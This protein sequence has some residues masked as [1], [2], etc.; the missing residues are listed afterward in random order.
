MRLQGL[1]G[2]VRLQPRPLAPSHLLRE[3]GPLADVL[4]HVLHDLP[5]RF[6]YVGPVFR[7]GRQ[8]RRQGF[9]ER[10]VD[11]VGFEPFLYGSSA[12][13]LPRAN[14]AFGVV[15]T[16]DDQQTQFPLLGV[17]T[18]AQGFEPT[19][20]HVASFVGHALEADVQLP[21]LA[22]TRHGD[23]LRA[24]LRESQHVRVRGR[25]WG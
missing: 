12:G 21:D 9:H 1:R 25:W 18:P 19:R 10:S 15:G 6:A 7:H 4:H 2:R 16:R 24:S 8:I 23:A 5:T 3:Q 11:A 22:F 13:V 20:A 14:D 17:A